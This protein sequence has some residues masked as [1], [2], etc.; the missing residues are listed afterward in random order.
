[1]RA[2]QPPLNSRVVYCVN[3]VVDIK[4]IYLNRCYLLLKPEPRPWTRTLDLD[5]EKHGPRKTWT[6][7]NLDLKNLGS[8]KPGLKKTWILKN[9]DSENSEL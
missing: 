8:E 7:K 2:L 4:S 5:P 1:M 9:V 6:Q 3:V